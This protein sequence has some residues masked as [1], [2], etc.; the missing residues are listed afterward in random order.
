M[1][2]LLRV[3]TESH[4]EVL[5]VSRLGFCLSGFV[6]SQFVVNETKLEKY[7]CQSCG[8]VADNPVKVM[9]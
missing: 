6:S 3:E 5:M 2:K 4:Y 8:N 9:S 7:K 1:N